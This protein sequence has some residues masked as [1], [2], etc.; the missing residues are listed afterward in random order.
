MINDERIRQIIL[1]HLSAEFVRVESPDQVHF[2]AIIVSSQFEG[3]SLVKRQQAIY[4][5]LIEEIRSGAV[6]ALSLKTYTPQEW[7]NQQNQ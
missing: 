7:E 3:L 2:S 1:S 5:A 4:A 6:H